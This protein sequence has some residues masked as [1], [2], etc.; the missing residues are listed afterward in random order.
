M[1][2]GSFCYHAAHYPRPEAAIGIVLCLVCAR[3][4]TIHAHKS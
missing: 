3:K 1:S 2:V 4:S